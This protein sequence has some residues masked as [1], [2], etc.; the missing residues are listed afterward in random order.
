MNV[1]T[2]PGSQFLNE[3]FLKKNIPYSVFTAL[4]IFLYKCEIMIKLK[5]KIKLK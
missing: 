5:I 4:K 3:M 1:F 2:K